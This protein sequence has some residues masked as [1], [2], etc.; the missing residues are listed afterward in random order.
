MQNILNGVHGPLTLI[1]R[2]STSELVVHVV[3]TI[4]AARLA[5]RVPERL[6]DNAIYMSSLPGVV[7]V[8]VLEGG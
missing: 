3:A 7:S 5:P 4:P 8:S 1:S 2:V 6:F